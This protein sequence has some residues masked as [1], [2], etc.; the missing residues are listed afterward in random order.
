[1]YVVHRAVIVKAVVVPAPAL[2]ALAEV[3]VAIVDSAIE[4]HSR[5]PVA[6]MEDKSSSAPPPPAW[7]PE[8]TGHRHQDPRTGHPVVVPEVVVVGPVARSPD[9]TLVWA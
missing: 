1:V 6:C 4:A 2:I 9:I 3:T 7:S 8:I 5:A